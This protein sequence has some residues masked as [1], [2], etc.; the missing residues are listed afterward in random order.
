MDKKNK[1]KVG[2][3]TLAVDR[4]LKIR[5]FFPTQDA[6]NY[7]DHDFPTPGYNLVPSGYLRMEPSSLKTKDHLGR[8]QFV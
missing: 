3:Q 2:Q 8:E 4:R 7:L 1:V 5:K 6:P